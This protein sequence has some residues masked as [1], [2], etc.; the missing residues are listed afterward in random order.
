V[1]TF[2]WGLALI[3]L[4]AL[5]NLRGAALRGL[6]HI[7]EGLL[8]EQMLLPGFFILLL[9]GT[10]L[11]AR[12][13]LSPALAMALQVAAAALAFF[14]G[15]ILLWRATPVLV[16]DA[17]PVYQNRRWFLSTLPL[18]FVDGMSIL[19][20]QIGIVIL[21]MFAQPADVGLFR[22]AFQISGLTSVGLV[23][24]NMVVAPQFAQM[25]ANG[26]TKQL[27]HLAT[28]SARMVLMLTLP[29][30]LFF[31]LAGKP[32]LNIFF[33]TEY[34]PAYVPLVIM[35]I[36]QLVNSATGSV[37]YL[38]NMSGHERDTAFGMVGSYRGGGSGFFITGCLECAVVESRTS[39][40]QHQ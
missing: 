4:V 12:S 17:V 8:P 15:A 29:L 13:S 2:Y 5:S 19:N 1:H 31:L 25:Y 14:F 26:D 36:G 6:Q 33:G 3:L 28:T 23:A 39:P 30:A 37:G 32:T 16:R 27:Q 20:N 7:F 38:L 34:G 35:I 24:I 40:S 22:V 11:F 18:A 21:G 9:G 10:I